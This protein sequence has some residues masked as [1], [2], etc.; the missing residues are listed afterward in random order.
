[1][2][3]MVHY[4]VTFAGNLPSLQ[5]LVFVIAFISGLTMAI[6]ALFYQISGARKD[7][8]L[9]KR[10][11]VGLLMG[12]FLMSLEY[13][14]GMM[15]QTVFSNQADMQIIN[16]YAPIGGD[17]NVKKGIQAVVGI[18]TLL[19]WVFAVIGLWTWRDGSIN[20]QPGAFKTGLWHILGGV[21]CVN[22][23]VLADILAV[24][25]GAIPAGSL[26]FKF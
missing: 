1:M 23:Y 8:G 16:T 18:I 5:N 7:Q 2:E 13:S 4:I 15:S 19:G 9:S 12:M 24:S 17:D 6:S 25:V 3:D 11:V 22:F 14:M 26:Y 20:E 10:T 21:G